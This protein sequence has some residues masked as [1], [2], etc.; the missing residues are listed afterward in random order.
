MGGFGLLQMLL[1]LLVGLSSSAS[2]EPMPG[3]AEIIL[4]AQGQSYFIP[5]EQIASVVARIGEFTGTPVIVLELSTEGAEL[6]AR[7]TTAH[8]NQ[9]MDLA[10]CGEVLMSPTVREPITG[11]SLL[12]SGGFS[13][14]EATTLAGR[15][16][17]QVPCG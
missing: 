8:L 15:I 2:N 13:M 10:V 4:T 6:L 5:A 16:A 11:G 7:V 17:G 9:Q 3:D 1:A 12:L 14:E